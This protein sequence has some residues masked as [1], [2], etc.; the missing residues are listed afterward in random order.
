MRD[1]GYLKQLGSKVKSVRMS[2]GITVRELGEMCE[3]D[4][5][6]Y[7]RFESGRKNIRIL[8]LLKISEQL[9]TEI[10]DFL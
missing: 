3:I 9:N 10:K 7:S 6:N 4:Y 5:S 1:N 2:K 8:T